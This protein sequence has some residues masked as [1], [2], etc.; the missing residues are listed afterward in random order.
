[1]KK[2]KLSILFFGAVAGIV[3]A[4][5]GTIFTAVKQ[6]RDEKAAQPDAASIPVPAGLPQQ[7]TQ[8]AVPAH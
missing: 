2:D 3:V 6:S 4:L 1:M 7:Q 5:G 8:P